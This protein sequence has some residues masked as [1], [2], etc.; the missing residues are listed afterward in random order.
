MIES[1]YLIEK[2]KLVK[3]KGTLTMPPREG[4]K[5]KRPMGDIK[6]D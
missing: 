1:I 3:A 6:S 5:F 4:D 2:I